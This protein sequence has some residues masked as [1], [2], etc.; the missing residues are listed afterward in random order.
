MCTWTANSRQIPP[1]IQRY[2]P[3]NVQRSDSNSSEDWVMGV[4][5]AR[6]PPP[7]YLQA[8][9]QRCGRRWRNIL[10]GE[11]RNSWE[12]WVG[13]E[14]L[15]SSWGRTRAVVMPSSDGYEAFVSTVMGNRASLLWPRRLQWS[16]KP[17]G[18]SSVA[19]TELDKGQP[20]GLGGVSA[21]AEEDGKAAL[22]R[23][24]VVALKR[25]TSNG[26]K[27]RPWLGEEREK[28][29]VSTS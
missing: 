16:S 29:S 18:V 1:T 14:W 17:A 2:I 24:T 3:I 5:V 8:S 10:L 26:L 23:H 13:T 22:R 21:V 15:K 7:A 11:E 27:N 9:P 25:M 19:N 4:G 12:R 6:F 28:L 20:W